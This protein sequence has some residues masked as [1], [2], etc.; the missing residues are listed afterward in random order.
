MT[1]QI[2]IPNTQSL[3]QAAAAFLQTIGNAKLLA[4]YGAMGVGKTTFVKALCEA[5]GVQDVVNSPTFAIVNEYTDAQGEAV[6][7]FDFY[8]IKKQAE[9]FDLGFDNYLDSGCF[10]LMEWPELVEE[11]LPDETL[12]I[13][14][15]EQAD[16][17]RLLTFDL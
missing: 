12:R 8:R 13:H 10:C 2:H 5:M 11:L 7:H 6:Y 1:H 3:P 14:L 15:V 16:G 4:F 9:L 17:S